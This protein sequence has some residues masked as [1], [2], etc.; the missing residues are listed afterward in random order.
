MAVLIVF[1][2]SPIR[3]KSGIWRSREGESCLHTLVDFRQLSADR[4]SAFAEGRQRCELPVMHGQMHCLSL[5]LHD[6]RYSF[7]SLPSQAIVIRST[8]STVSIYGKCAVITLKQTHFDWSVEV[9]G[10]SILTNTFWCDKVARCRKVDS[11]HVKECV[12]CTRPRL[13]WAQIT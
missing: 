11:V 8:W 13:N 2:A 9:K 12:S 7:P 3:H 10:K 4:Q 1:R 5:L 6:D